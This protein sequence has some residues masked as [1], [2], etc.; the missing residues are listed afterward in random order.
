MNRDH[1]AAGADL[2]DGP[3]KARGYLARTPTLKPDSLEHL[4]GA[5][6]RQWKRYRC[7]LRQC[8]KHFS[9]EAV[10]QSRVAT[11]RLLSTVELL[12]GFLPA[13]VVKQ[14]NGALKRQLDLFDELR[15]TQ[16]Q[17]QA[18]RTLLKRFP[19]A[20]PFRSYLRKREAR[21][22]KRTRKG[23]RHVKTGRMRDLVSACRKELEASS[24]DGGDQAAALL[25]R[26]ANRAFAETLKLRGQ[27]SKE[28]SQTIHRT[29]VAFKKFRYMVEALAADLPGIRPSLIKAMHDYQT[30]MGEIQDTEVLLQAF[31]KFVA[32]E[33]P[34]PDAAQALRKALLDRR[35]A[36]IKTYL[37]SADQLLEFWPAPPRGRTRK[38]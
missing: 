10:H 36:L 31:E 3:A 33:R 6:K 32:R 24:R 1:Q 20:R 37:T 16:V 28:D 38:C 27:I 18:V 2:G 11:R 19:A 34:A 23:I 21:F 25:L 5:L 12:A 30:R 14:V 7:E 4:A 9:S 26:S 8:Q 22:T 15:D 17:L 35:G 13:A 29:R